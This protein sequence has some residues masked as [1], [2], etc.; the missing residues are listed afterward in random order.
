M[1]WIII[2]LNMKLCLFNS[3]ESY[4]QTLCKYI[5]FYVKTSSNIN[6]QDA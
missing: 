2:V 3:I 4:R 1:F 5:F 6:I